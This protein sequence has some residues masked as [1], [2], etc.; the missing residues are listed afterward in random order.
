MVSCEL[1]LESIFVK[2]AFGDVH[3]SSIVHKDIDGWNIVPGK[4]LCGSLT[5][6]LLAREIELESTILYKREVCFERVDTFL[7]SGW[8]ATCYDEEGRSL[9]GLTY[10]SIHDKTLGSQRPLTK[11]FD[12]VNPIP[13]RFTPV[14]RIVFPRISPANFSA[15]S[16]PSVF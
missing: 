14:T 3:H 4:Q 12:V 15:T 5:D 9:R 11:A 13:P 1:K 10:M 6:G 2:C 8:V 16:K 7:D